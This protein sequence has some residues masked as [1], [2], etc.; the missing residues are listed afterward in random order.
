MDGFQKDEDSP[1]EVVT[2]L[3]SSNDYDAHLS[4]GVRRA[5]TSAN[6]AFQKIDFAEAGWDNTIG[7]RF[8]YTERHENNKEPNHA[9]AQT[10]SK[11]SK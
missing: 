2:A 4:G 8:W 3:T 10:G 1:W 5:F 11:V 9:L 6:A 7:I